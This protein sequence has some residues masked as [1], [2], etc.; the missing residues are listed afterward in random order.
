MLNKTLKILLRLNIATSRDKNLTSV[1]IADII[2]SAATNEI[3]INRS[4][5]RLNQ[6]ISNCL[7]SAAV[8]LANNDVLCNV[9]KSTS[10]VTRVRGVGCGIYQTLT[11]TI[12]RNKV[13]KRLKTL[14][15]VCLNWKVDGFTGHIC[16]Q[17]S[18]TSKLAKLCLRTTSSRVS[19]HVNWVVL[20]KACKHLRAEKIG[21]LGPCVNN[22]NVT[23]SLG[24]EAVLVVLVDLVNAVLCLL[25]KLWLMLRNNSIPDR[26]GQTG[27]RCV[28]ET[29]FLDVVQD[30][31][32]ISHW[33]TVT[34]IVDQNTNVRL[35]HLVVDVWI[36]LWQALTVENNATNSGLKTL[37]SLSNVQIL[38]L[39]TAGH[40]AED[41]TTII[42]NVCIFS[43][44]A[45]NNLCLKIKVTIS[46]NS[47][48]SILKA[49]EGKCLSICTGLLGSKV[50]DTKDHILRRNGQNLTRSR[51]SE[52]VAGEHQNAS[53]C[54]CL[55]RK[56]H[57]NR[58]LVAVE[59]CVEWC[60]DQWV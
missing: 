57:M 42:R 51:A 6:W 16:H 35:N 46:L 14:T 12:S 50:V 49:C 38:I 10:Q 53:L 37:G 30:W 7:I 18:H 15:E 39:T 26:N 13:L 17:A 23:L 28:V 11:S 43:A 36:I 59:V 40:N 58:H 4:L 27:K 20:C 54:L 34:A 41:S 48:E 60:A 45:D 29:S 33:I 24:E 8:L 21:A 9:D 31:L 3:R 47:Q 22:L 55:S 52:V 19:H 56:W 5:T 44:Y 32:N 2:K 25:K 1:W